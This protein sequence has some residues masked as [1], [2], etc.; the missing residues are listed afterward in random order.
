MR[1]SPEHPVCCVCEKYV[2]L[3]VDGDLDSDGRQTTSLGPVKD[4]SEKC[5]SCSEF[6]HVECMSPSTAGICKVCRQCDVCEFDGGSTAIFVIKGT[7]EPAP[8][9]GVHA[10]ELLCGTCRSIRAAVAA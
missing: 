3:D 1:F 2:E 8:M 6:A 5:T 4:K 10:Q 9:V 7:L